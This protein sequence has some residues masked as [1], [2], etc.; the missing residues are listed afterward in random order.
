MTLSKRVVTDRVS[1]QF[2]AIVNTLM[3]VLK[4]IHHTGLPQGSPP[5]LL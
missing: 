2:L 1:F 3:N 4:D 5:V